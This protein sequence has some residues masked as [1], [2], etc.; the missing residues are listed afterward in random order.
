MPQPPVAVHAWHVARWQVGLAAPVTSRRRDRLGA[1]LAGAGPTVQRERGAAS[2]EAYARALARAGAPLPP[3]AALAS[4]HV[5]AARLG[6]VLDAAAVTFEPAALL[7]GLA[8][9]ALETHAVQLW[10]ARAWLAHPAARAL[11]EV[12]GS[13]AFA[14]RLAARPG[15]DVAGCGR[16]TRLG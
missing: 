4:S 7:H 14:A 2:Q 3:A 12:I 5:D 9:S 8:F 15:Y 11:V 1:A 6:A 13:R 16:D 10:I